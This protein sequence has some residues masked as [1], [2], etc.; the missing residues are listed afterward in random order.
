L[1]FFRACVCRQIIQ[2]IDFHFIIE[3]LNRKNVACCFLREQ[4]LRIP[5]AAAT[6]LSVD[7]SAGWLLREARE[8][9]EVTATETAAAH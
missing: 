3:K 1:H 9:L 8:L 7:S 5:T 4:R 6:H 2:I